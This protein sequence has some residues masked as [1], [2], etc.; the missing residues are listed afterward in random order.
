[1]KRAPLILLAAVLV[2]IIASFT[3]NRKPS[4]GF[5][6]HQK[7]NRLAV[8]TLPPEMT[9]FYKHH[10]QYITENAVNPDKRRYA[11]DYEAPRH[12]ID[13]DVYGD[14][15]VY[16]MPRYWND[17][18]EKYTEDTLQAYG[19]VPWHVHFVTYQLTEAFKENNAEDILRYSADLGHY[20]GDANVPL[21]T[22]ENYN[23]QL[24]DQ[25]GIHGFWESRLPELYSEDYDFFV[26]KAE[27]VENTQIAIWDA[28]K[29]AHLALD[30][31]F[32]FEKKLTKKMD[33]DTKYSSEL[34]G[35]VNV[36]VY[37]R[38]FS[39]A[40]HKMLSGQVERRMRNSIK[41]VGDFWY[42]AWVNAGQPDLDL[43]IDERPIFSRDEFITNSQSNKLRRHESGVEN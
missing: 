26:G 25:Y 4:W 29:E 31:V 39:K 3:F 10:I 22:T 38:N 16:K 1:M 24:T 12:Y 42:T 23:G 41:M 11:V 36:K 35:N 32:S 15:A 8:F 43:L 21:H 2:Q 40:Y 19:I 20:I 34:R 18:I 27:Y 28:V 30:S 33:D 9:T 5:F 6:A 14:S 13:L 7:I 37:S 17:A